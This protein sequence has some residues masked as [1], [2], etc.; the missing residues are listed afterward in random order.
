MGANCVKSGAKKEKR[1]KSGKNAPLPHK[2]A[3]PPNENLSGQPLQQ[4]RQKQLLQLQ[5]QQQQSQQPP[6]SGQSLQES[7]LFLDITAPAAEKANNTGFLDLSANSSVALANSPRSSTSPL[8]PSQQQHIQPFP[9]SVSTSS[10]ASPTAAEGRLGGK[11]SASLPPENLLRHKGGISGF[12]SL[13]FRVAEQSSFGGDK[14]ALMNSSNPS[15]GGDENQSRQR[16]FDTSNADDNDVNG[17]FDD[18]AASE[19]TSCASCGLK[20]PVK[21]LR[22][23]QSTC[24]QLANFSHQ[25]FLKKRAMS[26]EQLFPKGWGRSQ[27]VALNALQRR[28]RHTQ[29]N[30]ASEISLLDP[31]PPPSPLP[32][33]RPPLP[34][35]PQLAA[36]LLSGNSLLLPAS[37]YY[38]VAS[39]MPSHRTGLASSSAS[40][41]LSKTLP[42]PIKLPTFPDSD[43]NNSGYKHPNDNLS[44]GNN[45]NGNNTYSDYSDSVKTPSC[46]NIAA[47]TS[48][49]IDTLTPLDRTYATLQSPSLSLF[50]HSP[51]VLG[52]SS[53][54][55]FDFAPITAALGTSHFPTPPHGST[56]AFLNSP[57]A[58]PTTFTCPS[59]RR[60]RKKKKKR[61][62]NFD[63]SYSSTS[64]QEDSPQ[65][66]PG[67]TVSAPTTATTTPSTSAPSTPRTGQL[68]SYN[69][70]SHSEIRSSSTT[71]QKPP[72][73]PYI[74][75]F[76]NLPKPRT[77]DNS[78]NLTSNQQS[79]SHSR[80][81]TLAT[82]MTPPANFN[83]AALGPVSDWVP[84]SGIFGA[85]PRA[86]S[87]SP[88]A[89]YLFAPRRRPPERISID[90][91]HASRTRSAVS[92]SFTN[93]TSHTPSFFSSSQSSQRFYPPSPASGPTLSSLEDELRD[94]HGAFSC[95]LALRLSSL[96]LIRKFWQQGNVTG[97]LDSLA[98]STDKVV[99]KDVLHGVA[100]HPETLNPQQC[101]RLQAMRAKLLY[102]RD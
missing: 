95:A 88:D 78:T 66:V 84:S 31:Q 55:T 68:P 72:P 32:P 17:D 35:H 25:A 2:A 28:A 1:D 13:L 79:R 85:F 12:S 49:N 89:G 74:Q 29:A 50:A 56:S 86:P 83:T 99:I 36:P 30:N 76:Y 4:L 43:K 71:G 59:K 46:N 54:G 24:L 91:Q 70:N 47:T 42:S 26:Q 45:G 21:A 75:I 58:D 39:L 67:I 64:T 18:S 77:T 3:V 37:P 7:T 51:S 53:F 14:R 94:G 62:S 81:H 61:G 60:S 38:A 93:D 20:F 90:F 6:Q 15:D 16:T 40:V 33:S 52:R 44:E 11:R 98:L 9:T 27:A 96:R 57:F 101:Q 34:P 63:S 97:L 92:S 48:N 73:S 19:P 100:C 10:P 23:H 22:K 8:V 65:L 69:T 5:Q 82:T 80:D 102:Q 41:L 87:P